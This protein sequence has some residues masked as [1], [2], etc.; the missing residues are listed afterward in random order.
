MG[1]FGKVGGVGAV[2]LGESRLRWFIGPA[3]YFAVT[4]LASLVVGIGP[5]FGIDWGLLVVAFGV[6]K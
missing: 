3:V 2:V 4:A 5:W 6:E 1:L